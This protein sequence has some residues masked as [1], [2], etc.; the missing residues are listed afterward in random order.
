VAGVAEAF[1]QAAAPARQTVFFQQREERLIAAARKARDEFGARIIEPD[2]GKR[3][4]LDLERQHFA[5]DENAVA[6]ENDGFDHA[7][8]IIENSPAMEANC[9]IAAAST[10]ACQIAL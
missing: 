2:L 7:W 4:E 1:R 5:V 6:I 3:A 10:K 8:E 9:R